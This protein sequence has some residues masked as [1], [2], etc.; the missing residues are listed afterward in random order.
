MVEDPTRGVAVLGRWRPLLM[1][2]G[3]GGE[4]VG[5]AQDQE[6]FSALVAEALLPRLRSFITNEWDFRGQW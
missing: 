2:A 1:S 4:G 6:L 3:R 5:L